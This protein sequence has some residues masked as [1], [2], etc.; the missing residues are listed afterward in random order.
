VHHRHSLSICN[1][2]STPACEMLRNRI[3]CSCRQTVGT[4]N[5]PPALRAMHSSA[6]LITQDVGSFSETTGQLV[7]LGMHLCY[8]GYLRVIPNRLPPCNERCRCRVYPV[9]FVPCCFGRTQKH[10]AL[11]A[12]APICRGFGCFLDP[13]LLAS[14]PAFPLLSGEPFYLLSEV[15]ELRGLAAAMS[16]V[17]SLRAGI[18]AERTVAKGFSKV[19]V[20]GL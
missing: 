8:A 9:H 19:A 15:P 13:L 1:S 16:A 3:A 4:A 6:S 12:L 2:V 20:Q 18:L 5:P 14:N 7:T 11:L 17:A 10:R